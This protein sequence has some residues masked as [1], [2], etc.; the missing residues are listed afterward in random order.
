MNQIIHIDK[1]LIGH[2][3]E[4]P[5][6]CEHFNEYEDFIVYYEYYDLCIQ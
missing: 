5:V 4:I 2:A 3:R 1:Q 6:S